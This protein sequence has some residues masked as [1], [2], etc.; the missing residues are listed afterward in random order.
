[1]RAP[2]LVSKARPLTLVALDL[3]VV[4]LGLLLGVLL[5]LLGCFASAW[6]V[7]F[8]PG[9]AVRLCSLASCGPTA[10]G[11][12][13]FVPPGMLVSLAGLILIVIE[14]YSGTGGRRASGPGRPA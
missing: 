4:L 10:D 12:Y 8:G 14:V 11:S 13:T 3:R 9:G 7:V 1:V 5:G 2:V 6:V